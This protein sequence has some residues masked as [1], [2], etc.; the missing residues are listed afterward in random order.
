MSDQGQGRKRS[1]VL[2][3]PKP[4][5][6]LW[7]KGVAYRGRFFGKLLGDI[8]RF[9][10]QDA[11]TSPSP[12][13][14]EGGRGDEGQ[15]ARE[16]SKPR[17]APDNSTLESPDRGAGAYQHL[18]DTNIAKSVTNRYEIVSFLHVISI[19]MAGTILS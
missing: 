18:D 5:N 7:E 19:I 4:F 16:C 15:N 12:L 3:A 10:H 1:S 14:G 2:S 6:P 8:A 9:R 11:Q 17:I 13:V